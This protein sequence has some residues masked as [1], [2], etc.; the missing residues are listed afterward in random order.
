MNLITVLIILLI[1]GLALWFMQ[2]YAPIPPVVKTIIWIVVVIVVIVWLLSVLG[3]LP[4]L[5]ALTL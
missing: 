2:K 4:S 3:L 5:G 1:I